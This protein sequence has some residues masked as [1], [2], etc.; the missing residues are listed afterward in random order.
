VTDRNDLAASEDADLQTLYRS[1]PREQVPTRLDD[2]VMR[3]A[4]RDLEKSAAFGGFLHW[5]QPT[6]I[7]AALAL[8]VALLFQWNDLPLL[9]QSPDTLSNPGSGFASEAANSPARMRKFGETATHRFL[10][11]DTDTNSVAIPGS[12]DVSVESHRSDSTPCRDDQIAT[13]DSWVECIAI[14]REEGFAAAA[15]AEQVRFD[16][17]HP[18]FQIAL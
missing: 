7:A 8:T 6:A 10:G 1:G 14:L 16:R 2:I 4:I 9:R 17:A 15:K 12:N 13:T 3:S 11:E 18:G 5:R